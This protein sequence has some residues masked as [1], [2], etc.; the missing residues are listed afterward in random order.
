M[1]KLFGLLALLGCFTFSG[2]FKSEPEEEGIYVFES[3]NIP[4]DGTVN[5]Y[6]CTEAEKETATIVANSCESFNNGKI[7]AKVK[8]GKMSSYAVDKE[9]NPL[10]GYEIV[11]VEYKIEDGELLLMEEDKW[12]IHGTYKDGV[13]T[14]TRGLMEGA[15]IVMRKK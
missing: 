4:V 1:K 11:E 5:A 7:R 6:A 10:E 14:L 9:G 8:D 12:M 3:L 2:C 13:I 15:A